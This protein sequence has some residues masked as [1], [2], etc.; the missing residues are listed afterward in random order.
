MSNYTE[1]QVRDLTSQE[2]WTFAECVAYAQKE[3][4]KHRSVISK[5]KSLGL[6]YEPKPV[7]VT[8]QGEPVIL[9]SVYISAIQAAVGITLPTLSK[10]TKADL[11][12]LAEAV[13][14]TMEQS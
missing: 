6:E 2:R 3:G 8:K 12:K 5:V 4:L 7:K 9:K 1:E 11:E 10:M 13:A 14:W